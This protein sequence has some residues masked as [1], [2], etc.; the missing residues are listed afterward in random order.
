LRREVPR[1][2]RDVALARAK[3]RQLDA[4][5]RE[6]VEQIV[7]KAPAL[8]F[9]IEIAPRRREDAHVDACELRVAEPLH[10]RSRP[11]L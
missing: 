4:R 7:A 6:P 8:D 9:S 2:D 5:H 3:R 11:A 10:L 1:E